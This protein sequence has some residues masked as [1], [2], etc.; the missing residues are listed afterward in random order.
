MSRW[1]TIKHFFGK[2]GVEVYDYHDSWD[3]K[4]I[5]NIEIPEKL[6]QKNAFKLCNSVSELYFPI[7]F[8][9]DRISK[10]RFF[11]ADKNGV[12]I[13]TTELTRFITDINPIYTFT[14]L[15]YNYVFSILSDGNVYNHLDVPTYRNVG[16]GTISRW[17]VLQ[18]NM[19]DIKEYSNVSL[20]RVK[21]LTDAVK[22]FRYNEPGIAG[23]GRL[24]LKNIYIQNFGTIRRKDSAILNQSTL[25]KANK[26]IDTLLSVYSARYNVYA[27][28]G[29]AGYLA[30]KGGSTNAFD[31]EVI[32]SKRQDILDDINS[33]NGIT[34]RRNLWGISGVPIEFINTLATIK[35]LMPFEETLESSIKI[36]SVFQIPPGLVPRKDQSTYSNQAED[37]RKVWENGLLSMAQSVCHNLTKMFTLD[38]VGAKIKFSTDDVQALMKNEKENEEIVSL[39]LNN[40][41]RIRT[42]NPSI[43]ISKDIDEIYKEYTKE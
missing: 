38:K 24:D 8:Y 10:L 4:N 20:L 18:P 34:G 29:A 6:T 42:L 33:R 1:E 19:I 37:E 30:K 2:T 35:E 21:K 25:W 28:N 32:G 36:A 31:N 15:I 27:N 40:L 7:D 16:V 5:G 14:D 11:I 26:S 22:E 39:K 43:D 17:D 13:K 3:V 23:D 12:E 41:E 9:A